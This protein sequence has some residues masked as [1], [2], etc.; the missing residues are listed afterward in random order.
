MYKL[1]VWI[2]RVKDCAASGRARKAVS[3]VFR[4]HS[5]LRCGAYAPWLSAT[6]SRFA[7][8]EVLYENGICV[9]YIRKGMEVIDERTNYN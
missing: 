1:G 7:N 3:L 2:N 8:R 9:A 6:A 4:Q 5:D